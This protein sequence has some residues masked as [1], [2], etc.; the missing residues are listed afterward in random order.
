ML[1]ISYA[2][3]SVLKNLIISQLADSIRT[4]YVFREKAVDNLT[5]MIVSILILV[6]VNASG[7]IEILDQ[8]LN[9]TFIMKIGMIKV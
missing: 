2:P 5:Y 8:N 9:S 7:L 6:L 4:W 3:E 1:W